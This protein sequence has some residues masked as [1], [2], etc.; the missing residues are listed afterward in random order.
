LSLDPLTAATTFSTI[1]SLISDF[2]DKHK[3]V[4]TNDHQKFL[5]WLSENRH[6]EVKGLL[7][8]NQATVISIKAILN[9]QSSDVLER[10]KNI[11]N[12]LGNILSADS[13]FNPLV[14]ALDPLNSLSEQAINILTQF[15]NAEASIVI[16]QHYIGDETA[17]IFMDGKTGTLEYSDARFIEDDFSVLVELGLLRLEFGKS[18][19]KTYKFTRQASKLIRSI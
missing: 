8:Q 2:R 14:Q 3:E 19:G 9:H 11:D 6:D 13:L 17:Y 12:K 18:G 7:E 15:E 4:A 10:L 5:E 16:E 1:V